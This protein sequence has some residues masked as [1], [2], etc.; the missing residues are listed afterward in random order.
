MDDTVNNIYVYLIHYTPIKVKNALILHANSQTLKQKEIN[1][2]PWP[3][4]W[5]YM[6]IYWG[7]FYLGLG[8]QI[9]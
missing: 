2:T 8:Q 3:W 6:Q 7:Y 4:T 1:G 9:N 5:M